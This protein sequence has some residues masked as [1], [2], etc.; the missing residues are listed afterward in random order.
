MPWIMWNLVLVRLETVLVLV[1]ERCTVCSKCTIATEIVLD[2][3]D[4]TPSS[5]A[6]VEAHFSP[7]GI[8]LILTQ[9]SC[10]VW[11]KRSMPSETILD[12]QKGTPR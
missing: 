2:A 4:G 5:K 7:F 6:Q 11:A 10:T 12:A 9:D 3:P 8:V 1:Q